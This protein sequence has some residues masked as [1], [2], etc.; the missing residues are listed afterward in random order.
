MWKL[1]LLLVLAT[2]MPVR[3]DFLQHVTMA[4]EI[5]GSS[6]TIYGG[7]FEIAYRQINRMLLNEWDAW[8]ETLYLGGEIDS[9]E[10][11]NRIR[12]M[13]DDMRLLRR[14]GKWWTR[15]WWWDNLPEAKGGAPESPVITRFGRTFTLLDLKAFFI[16][17][18]GNLKWRALEATVD[19]KSRDSF[20]LGNKKDWSGAGWKMAVRPR[21]K[22]TSTG[23]SLVD[24]MRSVGLNFVFSYWVHKQR[25][26]DVTASVRYNPPDDEIILLFQTTLTRW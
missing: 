25:I 19:F 11:G 18:A 15:K 2:S 1:A 8:N 17:N 20:S 5:R 4:R 26:L 12:D 6:I 23:R 7:P 14:G 24:I 10:W 9:L 16:T 21:I 13:R 22:F 3:A